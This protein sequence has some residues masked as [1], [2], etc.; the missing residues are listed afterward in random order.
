MRVKLFLVFTALL[1]AGVI[2]LGGCS[3]KQRDPAA[4]IPVISFN[5]MIY[6][7]GKVKKG[8]IVSH[9]FKFTNTGSEKLVIGR[10][11][12]S[13]GCTAAMVSSKELLPGASGVITVHFD[14]LEYLGPVEKEITVNSNDPFRRITTLTIRGDVVPGKGGIH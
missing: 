5:R 7:F 8:D 2:V 14:S 11:Q 10:I 6:D 9:E 1:T 13:C 4:D 12:T 3:Q